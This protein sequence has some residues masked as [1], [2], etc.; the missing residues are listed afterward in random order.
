MT[1]A[2]SSFFFLRDGATSTWCGGGNCVLKT[3]AKSAIGEN[4]VNRKPKPK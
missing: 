1:T 2:D 4:H 3:Q